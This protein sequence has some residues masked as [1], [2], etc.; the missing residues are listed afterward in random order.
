VYN[1]K[2]PQPL[3][4]ILQDDALTGPRGPD[5]RHE[6]VVPDGWLL[7]SAWIE[8]PLPRLLNCAACEGG[9]CDRCDRSGAVTTRPRKTPDEVVEVQ[10]PGQAPAILRVPRRGGLP[11]AEQGD[12]G[13]GVLLL[14]IRIGAAP[15][16]GLRRIPDRAPPRPSRP[17]SP[18]AIVRSGVAPDTLLT[19]ER[20]LVLAALC[21]AL[22]F[23]WLLTR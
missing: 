6:I 13:R 8:V 22:V 14:A 17:S 5:G 16:E 23:L 4:R 3:A 9:G 7:E 12:L 21:F 18:S 10:L 2:V 20:F 15:T 1:Q 11:S 19:P